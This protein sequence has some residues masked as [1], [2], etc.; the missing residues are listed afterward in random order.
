[1]KFVRLFAI[2]VSVLALAAAP[3]HAATLKWGAQNDILTLDP[4]S[5]NHATTHSILQHT[6]EGMVLRVRIERE[7]VVLRSPLQR[8][9]VNV[10][11]NGHEH[12][13]ERVKPM[14]SVQYF[15]SGAAGAMS[16]TFVPSAIS[17]GWYAADQHFML[18]EIVGDLF[19]FQTIA[20]DG[21]GVD[22][23]VRVAVSGRSRSGP[24]D[25]SGDWPLSHH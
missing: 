5:Q 6:Y 20:R 12:V 15:V 18:G 3:G 8:Y 4:H 11:F 10:V 9:G 7:Y 17:R 19:Y 16:Q 21:S 2:A 25:R 24:V 22:A 13:Y 14:N 23:G 1:M